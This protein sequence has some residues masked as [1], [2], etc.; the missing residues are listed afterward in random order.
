MVGFTCSPM[1]FMTAGFCS[2]SALKPSGVDGSFGSSGFGILKLPSFAP[3][4]WHVAQENSAYDID[5]GQ[6]LHGLSDNVFTPHKHIEGADRKVGELAIVDLQLRVDD[7]HQHFAPASDCDHISRVQHEVRRCLEYL[8]APT[9]A[10]HKEA[11]LRDQ[12]LNLG[13]GFTSGSPSIRQAI[14][15]YFVRAPSRR[16]T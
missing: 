7:E 4:P 15:A 13:D 3:D 8:R 6:L 2:P 9:D 10:F 11:G 5:L 1:N 14:T 12:T 16:N